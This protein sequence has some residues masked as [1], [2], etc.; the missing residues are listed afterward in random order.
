[1]KKQQKII[2]FRQNA[3]LQGK[4]QFSA[5]QKHGRDRLSP[6]LINVFGSF[7]LPFVSYD[8]THNFWA[9]I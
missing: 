3:L 8:G 5:R 1:M 2:I 9:A 6:S 4:L 7:Q